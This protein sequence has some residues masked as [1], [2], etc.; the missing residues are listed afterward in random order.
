MNSR[1]GRL[2][3]ASV[4]VVGFG[5]LAAS[6]WN[7]ATVPRDVSW[8]LLLLLT[9]LAGSF[10]IKIPGVPALIYVSEAFV[11]TIVLL[12]GAAPA[13]VAFALAGFVVTLSRHRREPFRVA[14]NMAEPAISIG[15]AAQFMR[16]STVSTAP[17]HFHTVELPLVAM[18]VAYF[19]LNSWLNALAVRAETGKP[20]H[21]VWRQHFLLLSLNCFAGASVAL[22]LANLPHF[23]AGVL[24]VVA[25]VLA[26][27]YVAFR[28]AMGRVA[29]ST[30]HLEEL[31]ELYLSMLE[32]LAMA[33]DAKDQATH[34]HIR[35][36]QKLA[37]GLARNLG[38]TDP[39]HIE[40]MRA[41]ALLHDIGKI[42]VPEH[43]LNKP[44][45]LT[46]A[47]YD[48]MKLHASV[49]G[50]ILATIKFR[51]PI[52]RIVRHHHERW[53]GSGYPDGLSGTDIPFG[54]RIMSVVDCYDALTSERPYRAALP[55]REALEMV[56]REKGTKFDP[57]V[58]ET[59]TRVHAE[60]TNQVVAHEQQ[61][62]VASP[63]MRQPFTGPSPEAANP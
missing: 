34:G 54:A 55:A 4:T 51:Y 49:G 26:A 16:L 48:R 7:V 36:V 38:V 2:Y 63:V 31:N 44:G 11:F 22:L 8:L 29:D 18:T 57:L 56:V 52:A 23:G 6:L 30:A 40:A 50:Q 3:I 45:R 25:S 61:L 33:I 43:I 58:V 32:T 39:K 20:A 47:E 21:L 14:F 9:L 10:P 17:G 15:L 46:P 1:W 24:G 53:D 19:L 37:V 42:A 60:L 35:R 41:A 59:F 5:V 27:V 62:T 28:A 12:H 13:V